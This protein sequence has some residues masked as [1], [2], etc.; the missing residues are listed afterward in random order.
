MNLLELGLALP[1][2]QYGTYPIG[3]LGTFTL[4]ISIVITLAWLLYFYR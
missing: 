1:L 4:V 3:V 2:S